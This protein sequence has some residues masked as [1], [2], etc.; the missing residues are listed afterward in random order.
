MCLPCAKDSSR[1][2]V[3]SQRRSLVSTSDTENKMQTSMKLCRS[4]D[5]LK[6]GDGWGGLEAALKWKFQ[7]RLA[8]T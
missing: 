3:V 6:D 7:G 8:G 4:E 5:A 1:N 2:A